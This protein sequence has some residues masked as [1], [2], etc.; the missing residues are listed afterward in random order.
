MPLFTSVPARRATPVQAADLRNSALPGD[1]TA[2]WQYGMV[3]RSELC[4]TYQLLDPCDDGT[5]PPADTGDGLVYYH[6]GGLRV[7]DVCTTRNVGLDIERVARLADA[8]TSYAMARELWKG[9]LT[10]A[11]PYDTPTGDTG[12]SNAYLAGPTATIITATVADP[13]EGLGLL[14]ESARQAAGG[15]QVFLHVPNR[16]TTQLGAQLRRVGNLI[17][18]QT[19]AIVVGDPGYDGTGPTGDSG[20]PPGVWCYAT[21]P[22]VKRLEDITSIDAANVTLDRRTNL[23]QIWAERMFAVTFDPCC[24]FALQIS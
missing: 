15:Q 6:P 11:N 18:T 12:I 13:M 8:V 23:R 19:D 9:T 16:I 1:A 21:G 7:T 5:E 24:H 4:P 3:W 22:V 17:Y 2:D 20:T 14:E 10:L